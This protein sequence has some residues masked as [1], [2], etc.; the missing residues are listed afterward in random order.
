MAE[1]ITI[2]VDAQGN[3][4]VE[5]HGF[6]GSDCQKLTKELEEAIGHVEQRK[7]KPEFHRTRVAT[8][9]VGA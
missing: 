1:E 6:V 3:V 2:L 5:G 8:R 9:K 7:L 4:Q